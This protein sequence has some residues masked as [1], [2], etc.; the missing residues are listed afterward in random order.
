MAI[1][2]CAN[3]YC[4][5]QFTAQRSTRLYCSDKCGSSVRA[6]GGLAKV[7]ALAPAREAAG[8]AT[9]APR[10]RLVDSVE[11]S[12]SA[13]GVLDSPS[14][15]L[16]LVLAGEV[17]SHGTPPAAKASLAKQLR[18][19]VADALAGATPAASPLTAIEDRAAA[20]LANA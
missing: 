7:R 3:P 14:G 9:S 11:A 10:G 6:A 1:R 17:V 2:N 19:T 16:A 18:E 4:G 5:K 8:E 20:K 13:A 15:Q 12:L